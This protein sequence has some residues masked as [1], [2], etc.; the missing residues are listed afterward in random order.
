VSSSRPSDNPTEVTIARRRAILRLAADGL[1]NAQIAAEM[2]LAEDTVKGH[3][4]ALKRQYGANSR[5]HL[6]TL[7]FRA[8]DLR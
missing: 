4:R 1:T 8:G 7:A 3:M 5:V 6:V 2:W